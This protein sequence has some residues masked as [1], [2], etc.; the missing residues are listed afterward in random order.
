MRTLECSRV[1][2]LSPLQGEHFDVV[3]IGGGIVGCGIARDAALRGLR[4]ALVE[5]RDF[6]SGT[7]AGSTRIVHGGLRYL[8]MLDFPLVRLDLRERETLLRIAPHLVR[9]LQF[10]IPFF[11]G[12]RR[13]SLKMRV[14]LALYDALSFDKKLPSRQ[15]LSPSEARVVDKALDRADLLG[16]AAY[17]DARV[18]SPERLALENILDAEI[19]H[20]VAVNYCEAVEIAM[21]HGRV[22]GLRVRDGLNG[23]EG[24]VS[25]RIVV[26]ATG[27]W[28]DPVMQK[29]TS[30]PS[31]AIRT[32]KGVHIVCPELTRRAL[33]LFSKRDGRLLFAIPRGPL[34]WIGTT[35]TDYAGEPADARATREDVRY[36]VESVQPVFPAL[37]ERDVLY[38]TSGVRA[39]V[40]RGGTESSVSRMHRVIDGEPLAPPGMISVLGGKITG[41]RAIAENVIDVVCRRLG[42]RRH[43]ST[44]ETPLP[45]ARP[46]AVGTADSPPVSSAVAS[47]LHS[48]HGTR[49]DLVIALVRSNPALGQPL[50]P[51]YPDIAAQVVHAVRS[52]HCRRLSDFVRR[53]TLLG[54]YADQGSEAAPAAGAVMSAE[55]GWSS[56]RLAAEI[57]A[58]QRDVANTE[59]FKNDL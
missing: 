17:Y 20:A 41:Y 12:D 11:E 56:A 9:P 32:T 16:A 6:G 51:K 37:S 8:E 44:A 59:S 38:T 24:T 13:T 43:G 1:G 31:R 40:R 49:A 23:D 48:L 34:T 14:G 7:T 18:D 36:L 3:I 52:E 54:T 35:D 4:V 58:Y 15:W 50:S 29:L 42:A 26:N 30:R 33:V 10:L 53:R 21:N 5:K 39:L 28:F 46:V 27:A 2:R 25:A 19:H 47:H 57:A 45:G 22:T 55:L